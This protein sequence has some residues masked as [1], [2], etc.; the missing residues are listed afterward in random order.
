[1]TEHVKRALNEVNL[2]VLGALIEKVQREPQAARTQWKK[3]GM[4]PPV[5]R[6]GG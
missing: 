5:Q 4:E 1:M 6:S 2:E 3:M